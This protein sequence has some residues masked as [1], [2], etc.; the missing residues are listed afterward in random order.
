MRRRQSGQ[1]L[2][3]YVLLLMVVAAMGKM[4]NNQLS[5][6]MGMVGAPFITAYAQAYKYGRVKACGQGYD[7]DPP[8]WSC[9]G[10]NLHPRYPVGGGASASS[11]M[12]ARGTN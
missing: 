9:G 11:M 6:I 4:L 2:T 1:S 12:F 8:S 7:E 10:P 5:N 3:E